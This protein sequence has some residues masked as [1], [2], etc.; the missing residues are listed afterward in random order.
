MKSLLKIINNRFFRGILGG[1][2]RLAHF[3]IDYDNKKNRFKYLD[4]HEV[5][6]S[7]IDNTD[8]K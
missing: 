7:I 2:P 4:P 5:N 8:L 6:R 1:K 3:L